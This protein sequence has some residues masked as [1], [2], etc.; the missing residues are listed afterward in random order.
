MLN[1][2]RYLKKFNEAIIDYKT[3]NLDNFYKEVN[4]ELNIGRGLSFRKLVLMGDKNDID[5]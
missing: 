3:E 4:E 1:I 2:M 5:D